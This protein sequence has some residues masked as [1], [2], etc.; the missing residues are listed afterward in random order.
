M[1]V[2]CF[3]N[4]SFPEKS[5]LELLGWIRANRNRKL[6]VAFKPLGFTKYLV[7]G[8][9]G[10]PAQ[11]VGANI[12]IPSEIQGEK[13]TSIEI[14]SVYYPPFAIAALPLTPAT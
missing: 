9:K 10:I 5:Q 7:L 6:I 1:V 2:N 8:Y 14:M 13:L 3:Q 12:D 11:I 4:G